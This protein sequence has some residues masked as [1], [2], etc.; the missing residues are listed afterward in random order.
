MDDKMNP[1]EEELSKVFISL[2]DKYFDVLVD[3]A[4][5]HGFNSDLA[6]DLT[7][8][9]FMVALEKPLELYRAVSRKGWLIR[10][11][12]YRMGNCQRKMQY[13]QRL[14]AMM[15]QRIKE[16]SSEM[17]SPGD[18]YHGLIS[19]EDLTLLIKYWVDGLTVKDL[20]EELGIRR[21]ACKKRLQRAK[22][23]FQKA[24]DKEIGRQ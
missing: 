9:V 3:Y 13:V 22:D 23:R 11:L 10:T 8:E 1:T 19:D 5:N 16:P 6:E 18:M 15:A 14:K 20:M 7:Q 2:Y 17:L 12:L 4:Q 24:Y 21:D